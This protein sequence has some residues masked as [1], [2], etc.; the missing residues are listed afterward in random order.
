MTVEKTESVQYQLL[1]R[2]QVQKK[3]ALSPKQ[4]LT[5]MGTMYLEN[6]IRGNGFYSVLFI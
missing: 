1:S 3:P 4:M 2:Q 6:K 5:K